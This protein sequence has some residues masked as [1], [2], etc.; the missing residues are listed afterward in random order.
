M[1]FDLLY[2]VDEEVEPYLSLQA[3]A[4]EEGCAK[5]PLLFREGRALSRIFLVRE[6]TVQGHTVAVSGLDEVIIIVIV[7]VFSF[8]RR[9]VI[10]V[11]ILFILFAV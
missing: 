5:Q 8:S 10:Q 4:S 6:M 9:I 3:V 2:A 7:I 11:L 1:P